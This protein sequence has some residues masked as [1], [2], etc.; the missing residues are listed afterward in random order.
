VKVR[1]KDDVPTLLAVG[2]LVSVVASLAH[3]ALGH[4]VG[5]LL[6]GGHI[7][8]ITFLVFRCAGAGALADGGGPVG[9]IV[10]GCLALATAVMARHRPTLLRLFLFTFGT[11]ALLWV[12]GQVIEEA[13]DG[14]DDWGH[15]ATDLGWPHSRH[16]IAGVLG[17]LGYG[18]IMRISS[19]L[20][21]VIAGGRPLRLLLPYAAAIA[22]AIVLGALWHGDRAGSALDG[23]LS[24]GVAPIG[25]LLVARRTAKSEPANDVIERNPAFLVFV[26]CVWL[27]FALTV[28]GGVG[29]LS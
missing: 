13:F 27:A 7:T 15:V 16:L 11:L 21:K 18:A 17:V 6:D 24:F 29:R 8:L 9:V 2:V 23:L 5:C 22:S 4:G 20:G 12:C 10:M 25:Y 28:A 14:S 3:E 1:F 19:K 26:T